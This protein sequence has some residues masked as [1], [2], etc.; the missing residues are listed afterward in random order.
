VSKVWSCSR[1]SLIFGS[2][3]LELGVPS[4]TGYRIEVLSHEKVHDLD[5]WDFKLQ[6]LFVV[7][8]MDAQLVGVDENGLSCDELAKT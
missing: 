4:C 7:G 3:P 2:A 6:L 5:V 8:L 1:L